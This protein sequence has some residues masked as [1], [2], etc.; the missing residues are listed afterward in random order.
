M[1]DDQPQHGSLTHE[2]EMAWSLNT[3]DLLPVFEEGKSNG[4]P[5]V[6]LPRPR[7]PLIDAV[8]AHDKSKMRKVTER[9]RPQIGP[10]VDERDSLLQQIRTKSFNL[11]PAVVTRP[12]IQGPKTNLKVAAIL[13]KANAIRQALAGSDEDDDADSWSDS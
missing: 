3:S 6:K 12:S 2:G 13:E 1:E 7:S 9:V 5:S 11:K 4:N 8:A 10:Q